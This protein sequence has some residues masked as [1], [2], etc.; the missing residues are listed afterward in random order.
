MMT[1]SQRNNRTLLVLL[2]TIVLAGI[3]AVI[4]FA[5]SPRRD[6]E[7]VAARVEYRL[8]GDAQ[9]VHIT[10]L[11]DLG[12]EQQRDMRAPWRYSFRALPGREM[13]MRVTR[14]S[15][16]GTVGCLLLV[17]GQELLSI[18]PIDTDGEVVC[19]GN[20]P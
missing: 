1:V 2:I 15:A 4:G 5:Q 10:F 18:P 6:P 19:T 16:S 13:T 14:T 20:V 7:P 12:F 9:A 8:T 11:S 17:N 3:G